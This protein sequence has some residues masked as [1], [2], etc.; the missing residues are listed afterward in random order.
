M[1]ISFYVV[2]FSLINDVFI[3]VA[4]RPESNERRQE[5][6]EHR[7]RRSIPAAATERQKI[8]IFV[9]FSR[10]LF[11]ASF[12]VINIAEGENTRKSSFGLGCGSGSPPETNR[13]HPLNGKL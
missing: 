6:G 1:K 5:P 12:I 13:N 8:L 3:V 7:R 10:S 9:P 11:L 4:F 2:F